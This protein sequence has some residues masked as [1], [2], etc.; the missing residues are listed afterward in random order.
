MDSHGMRRQKNL[1]DM[2]HVQADGTPGI[3]ASPGPRRR[4][5]C[6]DANRSAPGPQ[7]PHR[8]HWPDNST[9]AS[10][11]AFLMEQQGLRQTLALAR[12]FSV[13]MEALVA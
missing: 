8:L 2:D 13:P 1:F 3:P 5:G 12:R 4:A 7:R 9:P 6:V 11:L 10:R